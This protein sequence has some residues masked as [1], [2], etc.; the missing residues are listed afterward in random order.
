MGVLPA[1]ETMALGFFVFDG[2]YCDE[3]SKLQMIRSM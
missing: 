2:E 3:T 1:L